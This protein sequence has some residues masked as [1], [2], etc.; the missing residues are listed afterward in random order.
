MGVCVCMCVDVTYDATIDTGESEIGCDSLAV[1]CR[2]RVESI[3]GAGLRKGMRRSEIAQTREMSPRSKCLRAG[4][5]VSTSRA[6]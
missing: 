6:W 5:G 1:P 2:M 3:K 4:E